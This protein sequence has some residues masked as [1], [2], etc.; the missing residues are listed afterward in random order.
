MRGH[1]QQDGQCKPAWWSTRASTCSKAGSR[2][3][4]L[5]TSASTPS[6]G[7]PWAYQGWLVAAVV[8]C[9]SGSGIDS[10]AAVDC[11]AADLFNFR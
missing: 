3:F 6:S 8:D 11:D 1:D 7:R 10:N 9:G 5:N 4:D 2:G